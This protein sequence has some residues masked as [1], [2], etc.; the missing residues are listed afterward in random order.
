[1]RELRERRFLIARRDGSIEGRKVA[2]SVVKVQAISRNPFE[3]KVYG[4]RDWR[5]IHAKKEIVV[6]EDDKHGV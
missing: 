2:K 5:E 4:Y 3:N 6:F 1:V